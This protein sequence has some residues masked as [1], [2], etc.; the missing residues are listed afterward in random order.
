MRNTYG[1]I[2]PSS[3]LEAEGVIITTGC[4]PL[5]YTWAA[6]IE[7]PEVRWPTTAARSGSSCSFWAT[8]TAAA[9]HAASRIDLGD[10]ELGGALHRP[11]AGLG[12]RAGE[13]DRDRP[14]GPG[15]CRETQRGAE[16]GKASLHAGQG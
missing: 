7:A 16:E 12:E 15:A 11:A 14:A 8:R 10:R 6:A 4:G 9:A 2:P 3:G 13:T 5:L 1:L